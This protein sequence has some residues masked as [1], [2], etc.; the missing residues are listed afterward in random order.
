TSAMT[1]NWSGLSAITCGGPADSNASGGYKCTFVVPDA[2]AGSYTVKAKDSAATPNIAQATLTLVANFSLSPSSGGPGTGVVL[3][4]VGYAA[5]SAWTVT[6]TGVPPIS[7]TGSSTTTDTKG[8]FTCGFTVP[9]GVP[10]GTYTV[11]AVDASAHSSHHPFDV[12][13]PSVVTTPASGDVG[14]SVT[15]SGVGF[16]GSNATMQNAVTL[17]WS[18]GNWVLCNVETNASGGFSCTF[19]VPAGVAGSH[20]LFAVDPM[21]TNASGSFSI[22]AS[23]A[24]TPSAGNSGTSASVAGTGYAG[25]SLV[26]FTWAPTATPLCQANSSFWGAV[27]C[28][29]TVPAGLLGLHAVTGTDASANSAKADYNETAVAPKVSVVF[30]TPIPLYAETPLPLTWTITSGQPV[31][32]LT[33][34]MWLLVKDTGSSACSSRA[35][36]CTVV[37]ISLDWMIVNGTTGYAFSVTDLNLTS[38]GYHGGVLPFDTAYSFAIY[39]SMDNQGSVAT[40]SVSQTVYLQTT[41]PGAGLI[42]PDPS[43]GVPT[44]NITIV[45]NYSGDFVSGAVVNIYSVAQHGQLVFT[46]GVAAAGVGP[47][48][49]YSGSPWRPT[50]A[51][52]YTLNVTLSGPYGSTVF[53]WNVQVVPA[54]ATIYVN[55]TSFQNQS[56]IH[57][58]G[59]STT[60]TLLIVVGLVIGLIV[61]LLL[62]RMV[63]GSSSAPAPQPWSGSGPKPEE[64]GKDDKMGMK[65]NECPTCHQSFGS[66]AELA[67]HQKSAHGSK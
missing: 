25:S 58:L 3:S 24:L 16:Q 64:K 63:W 27:S 11:S 18:P 43:H 32:T 47:K 8:S 65:P 23:I 20:A 19:V 1:V 56:L 44:G 36:P 55:Q 15:A 12:P 60:G 41:H 28:S 7:C 35:A 33:T 49:G 6:W 53:S 54:G 29:F 17:S 51:G 62:G 59:S 30:S 2:V 21:G 42:S 13:V 48:T 67:D 40:T 14:A 31:N 57:G 45:V 4:G 26:K 5:A 10:T 22:N 38:G 39:V 46:S 37:E 52:T 61:A 9:T 50:N 34:H 66:A